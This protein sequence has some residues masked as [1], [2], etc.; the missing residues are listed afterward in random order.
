MEKHGGTGSSA[1]QSVQTFY[2]SQGWETAEGITTDARLWEDH[3]Q[4]A[5]SYVSGCRRRV[6]RHIPRSGGKRLLDMAS[7]PIQYPEYLE[8][9]RG[10]E[11]RVCVD[12]SPQALSAAREKIGD[13]GEFVCGSFL[14][15]NFPTDHFD[16][17]ISLHTIYH[18]DADQQAL[19]V[20][21]LLRVTRPGAPVIIVYSNPDAL[22]SRLARS[23]RSLSRLFTGSKAL[24]SDQTSAPLYFHAHPI[25][26]WQ[27][28]RDEANLQLR[29]WRALAADESRLIIPDNLFGQSILRIVEAFESVCPWLAVRLL[30]YPMIILTKRSPA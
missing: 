29:P 9:S 12:L 4:V 28:F 18:I 24:P 10:Y 1:E 11:K 5:A 19:A 16:C 17:T 27:Q 14:S 13:H 20:R 21:E 23:G 25:G 26:W 6:L 7:G 30:R 15:N 8:Y 2:T 3:R 22:I